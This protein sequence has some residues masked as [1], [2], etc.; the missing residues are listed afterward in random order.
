M[1]DGASR[2]KL[3]P[4]D[5]R[6]Q[7]QAQDKDSFKVTIA[8]PMFN[9]EDPFKMVVA[10][11]IQESLDSTCK[12]TKVHPMHVTSTAILPD[13]LESWSDRQDVKD[14]KDLIRLTPNQMKKGYPSSLIIVRDDQ[15]RDRILIPK[16]QRQ[17]LVVKEHE[18]M[19]HESGRRVLGGCLLFF[20][21][22]EVVSELITGT[23]DDTMGLFPHS[24]PP[25]DFH[26]FGPVVIAT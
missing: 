18:T 5:I 1:K 22:A 24:F 9:L 12:R 17:R 26:F 21:D 8:P 6:A 25:N 3:S 2:K 14:I 13:P 23:G 10:P 4:R 7:K 19:I 20:E 15:S 16:C 11:P